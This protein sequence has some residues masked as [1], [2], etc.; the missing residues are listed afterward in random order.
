MGKLIFF[1]LAAIIA[2]YILI[3]SGSKRLKWF[4][5]GL[6]FFPF[7]IILIDKPTI[8]FPRLIIYVLLFATIKD[9]KYLRRQWSIFPFKTITIIL[10]LMLLCVGLFDSRLN[11]FFK[12]YRP[13]FTVIEN[14]LILFLTFANIKNHEDFQ[15]T[16]RTIMIAFFIMCI[17]GI[18]NYFT[19]ASEYSQFINSIYGI[20]DMAN[21]NMSELSQRFR[22]SS[23]TYHAIY[24]G[25]LLAIAIEMLIYQFFSPRYFK[26]NYFMIICGIL[27]V[28]NLVLVNSRTPLVALGVGVLLFI[29]FGLKIRQKFRIAFASLI[30]ILGFSISNG[31]GPSIVSDTF[32]TFSSK[33]SKLHGSSVQMRLV[34]FNL[35]LNVFNKSPITGNGFSYITEGLGYSRNAEERTSDE[36]FFGFESYSYILLIEQ[37]MC[38][39]I[40]NFIFF[41]GLFLYFFKASIRLSDPSLAIM[42]IAMLVT[43]LA[44]IFGTGDLGTFPFFMSIMGINAKATYLMLN[45]KRISKLEL[46]PLSQEV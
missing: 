17:Y 15:K 14:F 43:F 16:Y 33:G 32:D 22:I 3:N 9:F 19:R 20:R 1:A 39:I 41:I 7:S 36:R 29:V 11:L 46:P 45:R 35:S 24:Y 6:L 42:S 26:I 40:G 27:L 18:S 2:R 21:D 5:I 12:L 37:G 4:Y 28:I 38:G 30:L 23:F 34:Q 10:A 25:F 8:T 31:T 13:A 44:F